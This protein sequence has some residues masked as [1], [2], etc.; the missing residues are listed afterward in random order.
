MVLPSGEYLAR[1]GARIDGGVSAGAGC[2]GQLVQ[3]WVARML[4]FL[5]L[6][7]WLEISRFAFE[8]VVFDCQKDVMFS[9]LKT[10]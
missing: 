5:C 3:P 7:L 9:E 6:L 8:S 10:Q 4:S 1:L 2:G